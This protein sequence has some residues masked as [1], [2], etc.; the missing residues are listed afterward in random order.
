MGTSNRHS[1]VIQKKRVVRTLA[2]LVVIFQILNLNLILAF[3]PISQIRFWGAQIICVATPGAFFVV[4]S[5][6]SKHKLSVH[7]H[8]SQK[9]EESNQPSHQSNVVSAIPHRRIRFYTSMPHGSLDL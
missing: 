5:I 8:E 7:Y 1:T 6:Q 2:I 3:A 4:Y 9:S